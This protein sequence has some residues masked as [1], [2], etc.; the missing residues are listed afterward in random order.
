MGGGGGGGGHVYLSVSVSKMRTCTVCVSLH[1]RLQLRVRLLLYMNMSVI[2]LVLRTSIYYITAV[3]EHY[4]LVYITPH[5]HNH[6]NCS[7]FIRKWFQPHKHS[8]KKRFRKHSPNIHRKPTRLEKFGM[9]L[10]S[11]RAALYKATS[12]TS[13]IVGFDDDPVDAGVQ[14]D[15]YIQTAFTDLSILADPDCDD[16]QS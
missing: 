4:V 10:R 9:S 12:V 14:D 11:N 16:L 6:N 8:L 13:S 2:R 15:E 5:H 3:H 7:L 1:V